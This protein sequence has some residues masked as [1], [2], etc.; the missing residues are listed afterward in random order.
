M[1]ILV[2][3]GSGFIGSNFIEQLLLRDEVGVIINVD[4]HTYA[5]NAK[6]PFQYHNKY[7]L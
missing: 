3:G 1:N 5:A 2:T 6:L 7:K 4:S